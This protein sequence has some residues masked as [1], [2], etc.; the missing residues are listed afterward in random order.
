MI[1]S[2]GWITRRTMSVMMWGLF[3]I[4]YLIGR[5][6]DSREMLVHTLRFPAR[7]AYRLGK[8][9]Y[10]EQRA[11]E[12]LRRAEPMRGPADFGYGNAIHQGHLILGSIALARGDRPEAARQLVAAA[13]TPGSPHLA[14]LGPGMGLARDL[15]GCGERSAVLSY[16]TLCQPLWPPGRDLLEYWSWEIRQGRTPDFGD[17]LGY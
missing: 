8:L 1:R 14:T 4:M 12:L 2:L 11:L 17:N 15:L 5:L 13:V 16:L 6:S 9:A 3:L 10:A 7:L